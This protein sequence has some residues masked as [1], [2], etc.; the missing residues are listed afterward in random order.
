M[1]L[2]RKTK[3][4]KLPEA[5]RPYA[6]LGFEPNGEVGDELYGDCP[7]CAGKDKFY[8]NCKRG[9][10]SC[11]KCGAEGNLVTFLTLFARECR[12]Q[13]PMRGDRIKQL[14]THR[15]LP[16]SVIVDSG[17]F[18]DGTRYH[19]PNCNE[20][21][22]I[23]NLRS[24]Y[25]KPKIKIIGLPTVFST[26]WGVERIKEH[27][28]CVYITEGEWDCM[29]MR[30][31]LIEA[32]LED[33]LVNGEIVVVAVP[34]AGVCKPEWARFFEGKDCF[35][36]YD[37]DGPGE[38][39]CEKMR[40]LLGVEYSKRIV[41]WVVWPDE[42]PEGWDVRDF[43]MAG[44]NL[45][46]FQEM[47]TDQATLATV[48]KEGKKGSNGKGLAA[49]PD[50]KDILAI[51]A[52]WLKMTPEHENI[53]RLTYAVIYSNRIAGDPLW[54]Q[55]VAP[56]GAGKTEILMSTATCSDVH[57]VSSVTA[58]GLVSGYAGAGKDPSLVPKLIGK[59][60]VLKDFTEVLQMPK[61]QRDEVYAILRGAY[62]GEVRREFGNGIVRQ[63]T[64]YFSM[65]TGT[66]HAIDGD[67][68]NA[69]GE[70]FLK[71]RMRRIADDIQ[72]SLIMETLRNIG[73]EGTMKAEIMEAA[74]SFL[75]CEF[76]PSDVPIIPLET[77]YALTALAEVVALLRTTVD[78][79]LVQ[80]DRIRY[81]PQSEY[82]TRIAK[83]LAKALLGLAMI[84]TPP[85]VTEKDY[86]IVAKMATD[87]CIPF[88]LDVM[89]L[90][91]K[92]PKQ[93]IEQISKG[94]KVPMTTLREC[95]DNMQLVGILTRT[96]ASAKGP[97]RK[98]YLWEV[99]P[100][101]LDKWQRAKLK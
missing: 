93:T 35:L 81:R 71:Y 15:S 37:K 101:V 5:V 89:R 26:V 86:Q 55:I 48:K 57:A 58:R 83:Q 87:S 2:K 18:F 1:L 82:A 11:K 12:K 3:E 61:A 92:S 51:Y 13:Y 80:R 25:L 97:G 79:D 68:D 42:L 99:E 67:Q 21:G 17:L 85:Q 77:L 20:K 6:A 14:A 16:A 38:R 64:G 41:Q 53:L 59:V 66:T 70:R 19:F 23:V 28:K 27:T 95:M 62:D 90:L 76:D 100:E 50:F 98:A 69:M 7:L 32:G 24:F 63:Y 30:Q 91:V 84:H 74:Q 36:V 9:L 56:P 49:R 88:H 72:E 40:D 78:R 96:E 4:I 73:R 39:G 10:W 52:R 47:L 33:E 31:I 8:I 22:S 46:L 43:Y 54:L 44:G 45:E 65:V 60:C 94:I 34:G 29:A 75:D